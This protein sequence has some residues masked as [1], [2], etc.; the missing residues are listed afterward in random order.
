MKRIKN[1]FKISTWNSFFSWK[2]TSNIGRLKFLNASYIIFIIL[3][4][5]VKLFSRLDKI[6]FTIDNNIHIID[7]ELPFNWKLLYFSAVALV[8]GNILYYF[9]CPKIIRLYPDFE[10]F[11][12]SGMPKVYL[13]RMLAKYFVNHTGADN[14]NGML[15]YYER[16]SKIHKINGFHMRT[17]LESLRDEEPLDGGN[18]VFT[19]ELM[20]FT[21]WHLRIITMLSYLTGLLLLLWVIIEK[22]IYTLKYLI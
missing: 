22:V 12:K 11:V 9:S 2:N 7:L 20:N 21:Y 16:Y 18:F 13:H 17:A 14:L 4:I 8:I 5:L 3:P 1:I 10:R 6:K 19:Q 15:T